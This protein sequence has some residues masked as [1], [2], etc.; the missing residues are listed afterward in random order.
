VI[1]QPIEG[2]WM[3]AGDPLRHLK[4]NIQMMLK[5][6]ESRDDLLAY[7]RSLDL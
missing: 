2:Q 4:A 7:L 1:A 3:A 6:E 5:Q